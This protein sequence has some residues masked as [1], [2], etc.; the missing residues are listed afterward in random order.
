MKGKSLSVAQFLLAQLSGVMLVLAGAVVFWR[1]KARTEPPKPVVAE[2][3][4]APE[5]RVWTKACT[6]PRSGGQRHR[7]V[8]TRKPPSRAPH[9]S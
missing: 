2:E 7:R 3:P 5:P 4:P 6:S 9:R 8:V 1:G